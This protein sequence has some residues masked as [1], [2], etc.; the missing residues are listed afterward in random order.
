MDNA[1]THQRPGRS[2]NTVAGRGARPTVLYVG[3][4]SDVGDETT[5]ALEANHGF[6]VREVRSQQAGP[7]VAEGLEG[8]EC[9]VIE[10]DRLAEPTRTILP[11][12][13]G[14]APSIPIIAYLPESAETLPPN[15][16]FQCGADDLVYATARQP[17]S[18]LAHRIELAIERTRS[19]SARA[20]L[21]SVLE[22][23]D[24][25]VIVANNDGKIVYLNETLRGIFD[26]VATDL[27]GQ[28]VNHL[29]AH[30]T[31]EHQSDIHEWRGALS[32]GATWRDEV[33]LI[34]A[35]GAVH[36]VTLT[37]LPESEEYAGTIEN[38]ATKLGYQQREL[39]TFRE[40]VQNAAHVIMVTDTDGTIEYV[41]PAFEEVTGY[42][43]PEAIGKRPSLLK[44]GEHDSEFYRQMW[45][46]IMAG[47]VWEGELI[48][49]R[50]DGQR[51][52]IEQTIAPITDDDGTVERFVAVNT[53]I[54]DRKKHQSQ[55]ERERDRLEEFA[56]T[57]AHDLRNPL[58]IVLGQLELAK[59]GQREI[60]PALDIAMD[61][62][63]RMNNLIDELLDL[64]KQ[65][66]TVRETEP[67]DFVTSLNSVW[68]RI[69]T[70]RAELSVDSALSDWTLGAD[71]SRLDS[72]LENLLFNA[73]EHAGPEVS[74]RVGPL[75]DASGFFVADDGPGI[76][77][78]DRRLIFESGFSSADEG[79]GFG[80]AIVDQI[81]RAHGWEIEVTES[82]SGGARFEII[83]DTLTTDN[84]AD[85]V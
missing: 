63:E 85:R 57:V 33:G 8:I 36:V 6:T 64:S 82:A 20:T 13:S 53:D 80:L 31:D 42:S 62:L 61:S 37:V 39:R 23:C 79:T 15:E 77:S 69:Q 74:I 2:L 1:A 50:K 81:V 9:V 7:I 10:A 54:T 75:S 48:N 76:S 40:A 55:L 35:E 24:H 73:I 68:D 30:V 65:G 21:E 32:S 47:E 12:L 84:G 52:H 19:S 44:S 41:N 26:D 11:T 59:S 43:R 27:I 60:D 72:L 34:D 66:E 70:P 71:P 3:P 46:T 29:A 17:A 25:A 22:H 56:R 45:A 28:P 18:L 4:D 16:W 14:R 49:E 38:T 51:Y 83:T 58:S 5:E 67:V 78:S